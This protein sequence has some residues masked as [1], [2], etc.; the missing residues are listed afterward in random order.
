MDY[1]INKASDMLQKNEQQNEQ[2]YGNIAHEDI[3]IL[4]I[5]VIPE[6]NGSSV[7]E[8]IICES[9][10]PHSSTRSLGNTIWSN[11]TAKLFHSEALRSKDNNFSFI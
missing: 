8:W 7:G 11:Y 6:E 3:M 2:L 4:H 1:G 10:I 5:I 9:K